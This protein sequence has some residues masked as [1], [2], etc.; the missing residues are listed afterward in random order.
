[1]AETANIE[2]L[3]DIIADDLD[4]RIARDQIDLD[5]PLFEGG[6][7]LDSVVLVELISLVE[8]AF[9]IRFT[10]E[11]LLPESF[12]SVR[13]LADLVEAKSAVKVT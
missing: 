9:D 1:M 10:D 3:K 5:T 12:G 7:G 11:E 6:L 4:A 8:Q 13:V 2:R